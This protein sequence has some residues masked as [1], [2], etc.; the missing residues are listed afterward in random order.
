MNMADLPNR[1]GLVSPEMLTGIHERSNAIW[2]LL[3]GFVEGAKLEGFVKPEVNA[4]TVTVLL[5][6]NATGILRL[7]DKIQKTPDSMW[8]N[9]KHFNACDIDFD[10]L[11]DLNARLL[12]SEIVTDAGRSKLEPIVWPEFAI[13]DMT[14]CDSA[15]AQMHQFRLAPFAEDFSEPSFAEA[16]L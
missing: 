1:N 14:Q 10:R 5:W 9:K 3:T 2:E 8:K 6:Q 12:M 13:P 4:F 7:Q 15:G 11:Y 16:G